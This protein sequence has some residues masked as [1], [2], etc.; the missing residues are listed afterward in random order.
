MQVSRDAGKGD[1][2]HRAVDGIHKKTEADAGENKITVHFGNSK[3]TMVQGVYKIAARGVNTGRTRTLTLRGPIPAN[4]DSCDDVHGFEHTFSDAP[5][6][7]V[8]DNAGQ[9]PIDTCAR[10]RT[11]KI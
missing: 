3:I 4:H 11:M 9:E 10:R 8:M 2:D 6:R 7:L 5:V 1:R